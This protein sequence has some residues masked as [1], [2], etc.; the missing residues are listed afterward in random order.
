MTTRFTTYVLALTFLLGFYVLHTAY[1]MP[2]SG[3]SLNLILRSKVEGAKWESELNTFEGYFQKDMVIEDPAI[4][5]IS[6]TQEDLNRIYLKMEEIGFFSYPS[7]IDT[8]PR[9]FA[10][11]EGTPYSKYYLKIQNGTR[12]QRVRWTSRYLTNKRRY[13]DVMDLA[14]LIW[15]IIESTPEYQRLPKTSA[16]YM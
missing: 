11:G 4:T 10:W 12:I 5:N 16:G 6:L 8:T 2:S 15:E 1:W 7:V 13:H 9:G 14:H 3:S